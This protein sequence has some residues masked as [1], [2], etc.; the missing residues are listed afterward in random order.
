MREAHHYRQLADALRAGFQRDAALA[1]SQLPPVRAIAKEHGVSVFTVTRALK[2]LEAWGV[3]ERR[4]GI[5]CFVSRRAAAAKNSD[6]KPVIGI[7]LDPERPPT[8]LWSSAIIQGLLGS[9]KAAGA[10]AQYVSWR[11]DLVPGAESDGLVLL[12]QLLD[13]DAPNPDARVLAWLKTAASSGFPM[14]AVDCDADHVASVQIDNAAES[15]RLARYLIQLGHR[16]I[17]YLGIGDAPACQERLSGLRTAL[18]EAGVVH[19]DDLVWTTRPSVH[20][21]YQRFRAF[22]DARNFSAICCFEDGAACGVVRAAL[23]MGL[24]VPGD[25]SVAGFGN[26]PM[27]EFAMLPLT[28]IDIRPADLAARAIEL[29]TDDIHARHGVQGRTTAPAKLRVPGELIVRATTGP[30]L[31]PLPAA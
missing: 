12:S 11:E 13:S 18:S 2:L 24:R 20:T 29:L 6:R 3:I 23:E 8:D 26:L 22:R 4:W 9:V 10:T 16:R 14:V 17:A 31:P 25:L 21:A 5:G 28:T 7:L 27:G 1:G 19:D 15:A 30:A